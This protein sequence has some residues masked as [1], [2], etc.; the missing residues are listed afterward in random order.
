MNWGVSFFPPSFFEPPPT[1]IN[2]LPPPHAPFCL[3]WQDL[4]L[5][6]CSAHSALGGIILFPVINHLGGGG[7]FI[8]RSFVRL[9]FSPDRRSVV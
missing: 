7:F 3:F 4:D 1:T 6:S 8:H 2:T 9:F 5:R